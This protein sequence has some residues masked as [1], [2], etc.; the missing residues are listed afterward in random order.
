VAVLDHTSPTSPEAARRAQIIARQ[1]ALLARLTDDLLD[2]ARAI[3]GKIVLSRLPIDLAE[4][5]ARALTT[6]DVGRHRLVCRAPRVW[7]DGD[8]TR[9]EQIV[10]N[11]VG[12]AR[13]TPAT[14]ARSTVAVGERTEVPCCAC[15]TTGSACR[16]SSPHECSTCSCRATARSTAARAASASGSR[17]CSGSHSCTA[18][19]RP[20]RAGPDAAAS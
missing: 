12:N 5:V 18:A 8:A 1:T 17:W 14:T 20:Q 3:T 13:S 7:V 9:I 2:A 16:P 10:V 15:A 19:A 4:V 6:I 11:L